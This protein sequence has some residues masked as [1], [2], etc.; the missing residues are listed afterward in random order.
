MVVLSRP[1]YVNYDAHGNE[2]RP[3]VAFPTDPVFPLA[4][5]L[6]PQPAHFVEVL[7]DEQHPL[8]AIRVEF[9]AGNPQGV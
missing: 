4:A 5:R 9:K 1:K 2:I 3:A 7:S 8:R 6:P